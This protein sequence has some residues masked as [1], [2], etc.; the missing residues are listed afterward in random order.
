MFSKAEIDLNSVQED[1]NGGITVW[2][3]ETY[4]KN[5]DIS[6][7]YSFKIGEGLYLFDCANGTFAILHTNTRKANGDLARSVPL[8]ERSQKSRENI[9]PNSLISA[10]AKLACDRA[11]EIWPSNSHYDL[12]IKQKEPTLRSEV[13]AI[14]PENKEEIQRS[15]RQ[16]SLSQ[17]RNA[18]FATPLLAIQP[19][20]N[21]CQVMNN[22][23]GTASSF[24]LCVASG[25]FSHD[26]YAVRIAGTSIVGG[27][28]D[29]TTR[30]I[31]G[32]FYGNPINLKCDSINQLANNITATTIEDTIK[33]LNTS[34]PKATFEERKNFAISMNSIEIGRHC[35]LSNSDGILA[36]LD[37]KWPE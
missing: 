8:P 37:V 12:H 9:F 22:A 20:K 27:I 14:T 11:K 24:E 6:P 23:D 21:A 28:D 16:V 7:D 10:E 35:T 26:T 29:D 5:R 33:S 1:G 18:A 30:G 32:M 36:K 3:R 25:L 13:S 17:K 34:M 19:G 15:L 4:E 31:D 2:Q